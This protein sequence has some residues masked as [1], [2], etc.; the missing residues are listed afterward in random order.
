[1]ATNRD[2]LRR[3]AQ[4][5]GCVVI[6][7]NSEDRQR[8][9]DFPKASRG[10]QSEIPQAIPK[11]IPE[12]VISVPTVYWFVGPGGFR[13]APCRISPKNNAPPSPAWLRFARP[14]I[15]LLRVPFKL[16]TGRK[17]TVGRSLNGFETD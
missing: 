9:T 15:T 17:I 10:T 11:K 7:S 13:I 12:T 14:A 3:I 6:D 4:L 2:R 5:G 8:A 16:R 1:M